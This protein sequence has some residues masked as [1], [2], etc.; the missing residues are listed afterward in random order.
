MAQF[1]RNTE[2][3]VERTEAEIKRTLSRY[4]ATQF[5]SGWDQER[6]MVA[7]KVKNRLV[8][9]EMTLPD[10][11]DPKFTRDGRSKYTFKKLP[12][13][14]CLR[15]WEQA[16]R[17]RW[18]ALSLCIKAKLEAV[19]TGISTFEQEF[20]ANIVLPDDRTIGDHIVPR[21]DAVASGK[22]KLLTTGRVP[23]DAEVI[24]AR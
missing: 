2:V 16:C 5:M 19:E 20:L 23:A 7:F 21:L 13:S 1:A 9:F 4:G 6:A 14:A 8:R 10:K 3:P 11:A 17:Q 22:L 24:D 12:E 15:N 18:R